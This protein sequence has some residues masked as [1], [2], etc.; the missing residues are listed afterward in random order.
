M[1]HSKSF[2]AAFALLLGAAVFSVINPCVGVFA[3]FYLILA[4]V[5]LLGYAIMR[6]NVRRFSGNDSQDEP[7]REAAYRTASFMSRGYF[8]FCS[9]FSIV[10]SVGV[11]LLTMLGLDPKNGGTVMFPVQ[12][13]SFDVAFDLGAVSAVLAIAA[14]FFFP[15]AG[16]DVRRWLKAA[17]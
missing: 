16:R 8:G 9:V 6:A 14:A 3:V 10:V 2:W 4:L 11:C 1:E 15:G 17:Q 12:L 13:A 5:A 7:S